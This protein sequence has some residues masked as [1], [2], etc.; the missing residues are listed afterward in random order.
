MLNSM[1]HKT[2]LKYSLSLSLSTRSLG[3]V[4]ITCFQNGT[5][6]FSGKMHVASTLNAMK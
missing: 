2:N 4:S 3:A 5:S 6:E 1:P